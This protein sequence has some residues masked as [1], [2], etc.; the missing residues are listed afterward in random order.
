MA[1]PVIKPRAL[2]PGDTL[3]VVSPASPIEPEKLQAGLGVIESWGYR[4]Q[5][6]PN[7]LKRSEY[8]AGSDA[9]RAADLMEAFANP[10]Y[11][12]VLCA[13]GGYGCARLL[14][15]LDL[16]R[17]VQSR[18]MLMGFSDITSLHV[19]LNNLGL[20]TFHTPMALT[21]AYEREPWVYDSMKRLL[22]GNATRPGDAP[23]AETITGGT[24]EGIVTGGCLCLLCDSIGTNHGL[25]GEG[26]ILMIEDVDEKPHRVDAMLTHL[27]NTGILQAAAGIVV[28]EMTGTD[29]DSDASIGTRPWKS[30]VKDRLEDLGIPAVMNFPFGH[31]KTMLSLPFGIRARLDADAGILEF[32]EPPCDD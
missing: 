16:G 20:V 7:A 22:A 25:Q 2:K 21:L 8:L 32:L 28:G 24:A 13:R 23:A 4:T 1:L 29:N 26:R 14:P 30:I 10:D 3:A 9:E 31:M 11:A 5:L 18:K 15:Y 6:L 12:A 27:R 19:P 17:I